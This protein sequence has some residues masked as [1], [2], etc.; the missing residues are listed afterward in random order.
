MADLDIGTAEAAA[1]LRVHEH[2]VHR[3]ALMV[4]TF[5]RGAIRAAL[6]MRRLP[7]RKVSRA[8]IFRRSDVEAFARLDRPVGRPK[9]NRAA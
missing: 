5:D 8:W 7:G 6:N 4:D 1:M 2:H 3:L 9:K